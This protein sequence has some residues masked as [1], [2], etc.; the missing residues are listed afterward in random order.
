MKTTHLLAAVVIC[1]TIFTASPA[2]AQAPPFQWAKRVASTLNPNDELAMGM[3]MDGATNVYVTGW[4]DGTNDFGGTSLVSY[5]GQDIFIAK[6]ASSGALQWVRQ[7]GGT[8]AGWEYGRGVGVDAAGNVYFTGGFLGTAA[9]FGSINMGILGSVQGDTYFLAKYDS[10][11]TPLWV[12][13]PSNTTGETYGTG[14][15]VDSGGNSYTVGYF[16]GY[17]MSLDSTY[18]TNAGDYNI[19]LAKHNIAGTLQ[20]AKVL[21]SPDWSYSTG[22]ALDGN[23]NVYVTGTFGTAVSIGP[24]NFTSAG[25]KDGFVAKFN[26]SG[27]LQWAR[28]ISG[29][30]DDSGLASA[31]ADAAG[32][33]YV[34]GGFG[35]AAGDIVSFG[36]S[37]TLTNIGGGIPGAGVGDAFVAKYNSSGAIQWA[38]RAGGTNMDAYTGV[39]TDMQGNIYVAGGTGGTGIPGGFNL[40][41]TKYDTNGLVQW[42]QTSSGTN[43]ALSWA[44]PLLDSGGNCYIAGWFQGSTSFGTNTLTGRGYWDL[45]LAKLVG[46][47]SAVSNPPSITVQP[48]SQTNAVGTTASFTVTVTGTTPLNYQ[49]RRNS[50]NVINDARLSGVATANL[51]ITNLQTNDAGGYSVVV[52]NAYGSVTSMVAVLTVT[53]STTYYVWAESPSPA[54]PYST[55]ATAARTIQAAV[56][57]A[58]PGALVWVTNG[59]YQSGARAVYGMSNRV[60]VTKPLTVQSVNGPAFTQIMGYQ[61]P[62]TTNG[63]AAVRCVYLT[64][65][66]VLAGF[67]LTQG[68]TQTSGD[69][70]TNQS[71]AGVWCDGWSSAVVTNCVLTGNSAYSYGGGVWGGTLNNCVLTGNC[72]SSGGGSAN[73]TLN[74]CLLVGNSAGSHGGGAWGGWL[75]NCTLT[76]NSAVQGG[77][78]T[79]FGTLNNCTLSGNSATSYGGGVD[80]GTLN[81]C[82]LTGNSS[83]E[84]G[85]AYDSTLNNCIIY[86]N[87]AITGANY[88]RGTLNY[89]CTTPLP[90]GT[91]NLI[92]EPQ[93]AS[94]AH[95]SVGSPCRGKAAYASGVDVDGEPW[96][97]PPSIGCDEYWSGSVTGVM[98]VALEATYTNVA[99]GFGVDF[100]SLIGGRVSASRWDFGDGSMVSNRPCVSHAWAAPGDYMVELRAYNE[101]YPAGVAATVTVRVLA[102]PIHYV[103]LSSSNPVPPYVSWA[104]AATNIQD[105]V[106]AAALPGAL[107]WVSNGVYQTGA[108]AVYG[109]SNR[110]AV[111]KPLTVRSINGPTGTQILGY[112]EPGTKNG[113]AAVR[114]V[115]LTNGA[116]VE[117]FTLSNGG[118]QTVGADSR[119]RSGGGVWCEGLSVVVSNCVLTGNSAVSY[120]G[121]AYLGTLLNCR[122]TNNS[123]YYGA[124]AA[125][126]TL[127]NC[128]LV[129]NASGNYGG[130]AYYGTMN[131]CTLTG[132]SAGYGGGGSSWGTLNNCIVYYNSAPNGANYFGSTFAYSCTTPLPAGAGNLVNEPALANTNGWSN[133][134]LQTN[135]P[136]IDVGNNAYAPG[137]TDLDSNPRMVGGAVD[138]GAY[139]FQGGVLAPLIVLQP[140]SQSI[141][142]GG[143]AVFTVAANGTQPLAYQWRKNGT[144]L[145]DGVQPSASAVSGATTASLTIANVQTSDAG[146]YT[147]M[148]TNSY[149]NVTSV[150]AIL[151]VNDSSPATDFTYTTNNGTITIT[152]YAGPGGVINIPSSI[153]GL[154]VTHIGGSAFQSKTSLTS[155]TIPD[156]VTSIGGWAFYS[157]SSLASLTLGNGVKSIGPGAFQY[158]YGLTSITIPGSVTDIGSGLFA[159]CHRLSAITVNPG[160]M[161]YVSVAGVLFDAGQ[162]TLI[163]YPAT[164]A[165]S[166]YA[167]TN[168]VTAIADYAFYGCYNPTNITIPSSVTSIGRSAFNQCTSLTSLAIPASVTNLVG[169]PFFWNFSLTAIAVDT[170][171][172]AYTSVEGVLFDKSRSTL[173][174]YPSG[175]VGRSYLIPNSV[176]TIGEYAF[177]NTSLSN[178]TIS[179]SVRNIGAYAFAYCSGLNGVYFESD[180]PGHDDSSVF[181][182]ADNV[183]VYYLLGTSGWGATFGGRP[184]ALWTPT[185][186]II[187][188]HPLSQNNVVGAASFFRVA[189]AGVD[190]L[191]Y[192]WRKDGTNLLNGGNI[193]GVNT[194]NL[195][196]SNLLTNDA[197]NYTVVVTNA[198]GNVTSSVAV[199]TVVPAAHTNIIRVPQDYPT[200]QQGLAAAQRGDAVVVSPG[201]YMETVTMQEG[202][203]LLG[204]SYTNTFIDGQGLGNSQGSVVAGTNDAII[205][206]FTIR[207]SNL[208]PFNNAGCGIDTGSYSMTVAG[209]AITN[210][211]IG[212]ATFG[213]STIQNNV[214]A[215]NPG[216]AGIFVGDGSTAIIRNNTIVNNPRG[217]EFAG[218]CAPRVVNNILTGN[219][220]GII[221]FA[222]NSLFIT[223]NNVFDN[224][225]DYEGLVNQT[226]SNGNISVSPRFLDASHGDFH[227]RDSSRCIGVGARMSDL[228]VT[229]LDGLVRPNPPGSNPD[230]GAFENHLAFWLPNHAPILSGSAPAWLPA[231][232]ENEFNNWGTTVGSLLASLGTNAVTD[233]DGDGVGIAITAVNEANG[234]WQYLPSGGA[235]WTNIAPVAEASALLL[236]VQ[237]RVR[238]VPARNFFGSV[239]PGFVFRAWDRTAGSEGGLADATANGGSSAFSFKA[240]V[241][242][243]SVNFLPPPP[244]D[245]F[246]DRMSL[247]GASLTTWGSTVGATSEIGEPYHGDYYAPGKSVWWSWLPPTNGVYRIE[248]AGRNLFGAY[249]Y[250]VVAVYTGSALTNLVVLGEDSLDSGTNNG[251]VIIEAV[252]GTEY[253]IVVDG[254]NWPDLLPPSSE[255][256]V[257]SIAPGEPRPR[258]LIEPQDQT[259]FAGEYLY[260]WAEAEG[261]APLAF[262]WRVNGTN[263]IGATDSYYYSWPIQPEQAGGYSFLVTNV[264]GAVTSRVARITILPAPRGVALLAPAAAADG[265]FAFDIYSPSNL[266][267]RIQASTNLNTWTDLQTNSLWPG[268]RMQFWDPAASNY[269]RRFY[270]VTAP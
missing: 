233:A 122:L 208:T 148:V 135:S 189:A 251:V 66:A 1:L 213:A 259:L 184:T 118:T 95:I 108:R 136:C 230:L 152:G 175:K 257:L 101:S 238:F 255:N 218:V 196:I 145:M 76:G 241:A 178:L 146:N 116:V 93:L 263:I 247:N 227:L 228:P 270:R 41:V 158:C 16:D 109:S 265:S 123:G 87:A 210:C 131:N 169:N 143:T 231:I 132:N 94:A 186:P 15:A 8:N 124:G 170:N 168:T 260:L 98:S 149:G 61:V 31:A 49:W 160:N 2:H 10:S 229:D 130:G 6:Y 242:A 154:P 237:T 23:G 113:P 222:S 69:S 91:G 155:V 179:A 144:N 38:Q 63:P 182:S 264:F 254:E 248:A 209:N 73:A 225:S 18:L 47:G 192:Q 60:A 88:L 180:A 11:G 78:G 40:V 205:S 167:V 191:A 58:Q 256:V 246:D 19:F 46:A 252:A 55:W 200:I 165:G 56:D 7:A 28:Q 269:N 37:V 97:N 232:D 190:P 243:V 84:G 112:Q 24:T 206:G 17:W 68:A 151:A 268:D 81:H 59:A 114:C 42:T 3:T 134:R 75:I 117:G 85:G 105:A 185:I 201:I 214:I 140:Q 33:V 202:V 234:I 89:C 253:L 74:N 27:V 126:G 53:G 71:G 236:G 36:S 25:A 86:Q 215:H 194:P 127:D 245:N 224:V 82:T 45:F 50:T 162:T 72:A 90:A 183:T 48:Q 9:H 103:A 188:Q 164:K 187:T 250:G 221:G 240:G 121:G 226:G 173:I 100:Q 177:G 13:A 5:G 79:S 129:G 220:A 262:Q 133:L 106:D 261:V 30:S 20:W 266:T 137:P 80:R 51:I 111:T 128:L 39:S 125:F 34:A 138:M 12:K 159:G 120:G 4:F 244:N 147:V 172:P 211:R 64:N 212:I 203:A 193:S 235:Q 176:T 119:N 52:T 216:L 161:Y 44:G 110:V 267:V 153:T 181:Y 96:A 195:T 139:E 141:F 22:V 198:Y 14:I 54:F 65:G 102:Q 217:I 258:L 166:T 67:T 70:S 99:A 35:N 219:G 171:N 43:G 249:L 223:N 115:Y 204:S 26:G 239:S 21:S 150:V 157:C 83:W 163:A 199:L 62:G 29:P 92:D 77:G 197:G 142:W 57:A 107:V 104:T 174:D 156:S 207:N 32:S